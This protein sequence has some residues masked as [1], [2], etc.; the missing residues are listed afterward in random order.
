MLVARVKDDTIFNRLD[1]ALKQSG[2]QIFKTDEPNLKMRTL[3]VP[4]PLPVQLGLTLATSEGY[5][6]IAS[7]DALVRQA[8][9]VKAGQKSGL[10]TTE[11]FKRLAKDIPQQGNNFTFVS[12]RFSQTMNR[13]QRQA[14]KLAPAG[15][16]EQAKWLQSILSGGEPA[17]YYS[18]G[19]N[20]PEGWLWAA[21]GNQSP[22]RFLLTSVIAPAGGV[23]GMTVPAIVKAR[24]A[25]SSTPD[26]PK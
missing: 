3:P 1:E 12:Q 4:L 7:N 19:A 8:L 6:F 14:L 25:Q 24:A 5:L 9:A 15:G 2:Q 16:A 11:E 23:A 10:K 18:V 21:N 22:S 26:E 13:I 17:F 20:T